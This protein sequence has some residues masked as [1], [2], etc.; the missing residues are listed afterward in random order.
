MLSDHYGNTLSTANAAARDHYDHGV[1]L[2]LGADYGATEAFNACVECDPAF[3]LGHAALARAFMMEGRMPA[4]QQAIAQAQSLADPAN[5]QEQ[6]HI[7]AFA[8]L[9]SG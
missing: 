7:A 9:L 5:A 8:Y 1:H 4:A 3:A 2:F 6:S